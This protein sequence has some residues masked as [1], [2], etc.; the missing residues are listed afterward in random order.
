[1]SE[2]TFTDP[3]VIELSKSFVNVIAHRETGHG[4]HEAFVGKE[5]VKLC[6]EYYD[7]PCSVHTTGESVVGRFF[8]GTFGT[9][10]TVFADPTGKE[11]TKVTGMMS[12]GE[13][14]K[15]MNEVLG[16]VSGDKIPLGLWQSAHKFIADGDAALAKG[17]A[18]KAVEAYG[19]VGKMKGAAFKSMS[20]EA[21]ARAGEA[22]EKALSEALALENPE[23]KKKA[24]RKIA[25]DYKPLPVS[26]EARKQLD[27]LK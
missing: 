6:N 9:P 19:R 2:T 4:E 24:L 5:K 18:K 26:L 14:I 20:D 3:K 25:D 21:S 12:T 23:D 27:T 13:L 8:Q 10:S 17:D 22:G 16:K 11:I 15:K 7:I 1:M